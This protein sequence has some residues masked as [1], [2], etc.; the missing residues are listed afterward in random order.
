M[1]GDLREPSCYVIS[2]K[3]NSDRTGFAVEAVPY[4]LSESSHG[5]GTSLTL[6]EV[7]LDMD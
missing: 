5:L 7:V 3:L 4:Q 2:L 6:D 1:D